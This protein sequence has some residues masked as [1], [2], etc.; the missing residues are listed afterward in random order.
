MNVRMK[1]INDYLCFELQ[2]DLPYS[3]VMN[4]LKSILDK[5]PEA[6]N[7]YY[8][9][10][11]FDFKGRIMT[12]KHL[13]K[14]F[15]V[16]NDA[17]KVLFG[18]IKSEKK[19]SKMKLIEANIY[20]GELLEFNEDVLIIGNVHKG[21]IIKTTHDLYIVGKVQGTL[22]GLNQDCFINVSQCIDAN[23]GI[24]HQY[25][26]NVTISSL[27]LFY[28]KDGHIKTKKQRYISS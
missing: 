21:A 24:F 2:P 22:I 6:K 8:P 27:S 20:G 26:Q 28:Y 12:E 18:G 25:V 9:K 5:L 19:K 10:A 14:L 7:G 16:L 3:M 15:V 1:G 17:K 13:N 11:F 23:I 4:D